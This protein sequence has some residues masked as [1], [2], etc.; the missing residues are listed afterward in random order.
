MLKHLV[1]GKA[2]RRAVLIS[3]DA[4]MSRGL[5]SKFSKAGKAG[6]KSFKETKHCKCIID[7]LKQKYPVDL[8]RMIGDVRGGATPLQN[9]H[10]QGMLQSLFLSQLV[11]SL[12]EL[13]F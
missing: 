3:L 1:A 11:F 4:L 6:K 8:D 10:S 7:A 9:M 2:A 12:P 5:Q 13:F